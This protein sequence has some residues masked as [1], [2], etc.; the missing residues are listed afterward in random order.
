MKFCPNNQCPYFLEQGMVAAFDDRLVQ[1]T[2]CGASLSSELPEESGMVA[3]KNHLLSIEAHRLRERFE[4]NG[5][6]AY[7]T[8]DNV[9][10]FYILT[11]FG[12]AQLLIHQR[13]WDKAVQV[14]LS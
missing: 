6:P 3:I 9:S 1:C 11:T 7:V 14:L 2:N 13:D 10:S 8:D 5:I 12:G 4:A